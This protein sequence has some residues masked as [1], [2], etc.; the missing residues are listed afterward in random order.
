MGIVGRVGSKEIAQ[1]ASSIMEKVQ[2]RQLPGQRIAFQR[3]CR[4]NQED[5]GKGHLVLSDVSVFFPLFQFGEGLTDSTLK[6]AIEE[7]L[8]H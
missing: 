8:C 6:L 2:K 4:S 3:N 1:N 7:L 5:N